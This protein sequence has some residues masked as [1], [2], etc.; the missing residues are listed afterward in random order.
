MDNKYGYKVCYI[1]EKSKQVA[2][3]TETGEIINVSENND[4]L[5]EVIKSIDKEIML[6][7]YDLLDG[8]LDIR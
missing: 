6:K 7:L 1:K 2:V 8:E 5:E 4:D 3:D